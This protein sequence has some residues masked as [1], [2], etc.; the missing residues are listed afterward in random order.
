MEIHTPES[1]IHSLKQ[2]LVHIAM[3]TIGILIA[4]GL[5]GV[6]QHFHHRELA[7]QAEANF[8]DEIAYNRRRLAEVLEN[9]EKLGK[10]LAGLLAAEP[11]WRQGKLEKV[12]TL[13]MNPTF[14][15]L[16]TTS[17]ETAEA[18]QALSYMRYEQVERYTTVYQTERQFNEL[19]QRAEQVWFEI[20]GFRG[21][22]KQFTP[23]EIRSA[24]HALNTAYSYSTSIDDVGKRLLKEYDNAP[25]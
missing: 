21:D 23:D 19:E 17:W 20:A 16:R 8:D 1:P 10:G 15:S 11:A 5:E 22:P 24:I 13:N 18:T 12:P 3:V 14:T 4:L 2:F 6:T 25:K 9:N 7:H